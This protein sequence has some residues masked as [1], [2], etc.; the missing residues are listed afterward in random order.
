MGN[1]KKENGKCLSARGH[2]FESL[3]CTIQKGLRGGSCLLT[4]NRTR[5]IWAKRRPPFMNL[6]LA[7]GQ[8]KRNLGAILLTGHILRK[9]DLEIFFGKESVKYIR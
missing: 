5:P 8:I 3:Q 1:W 9:G 4:G 2:L 7:L 6:K